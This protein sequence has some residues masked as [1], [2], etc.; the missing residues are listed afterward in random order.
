MG[1][2]SILN[3]KVNKQYVGS[4]VYINKRWG[5]HLSDLRRGAHPNKHLQRSWNL[6]GE[7]N[8]IFSL[9]EPIQEINKIAE[10]EQFWMNALKPAYNLRPVAENNTGFR[11]SEES[12][13][14]MSEASRARGARPPS[15]AG[16]SPTQQSIE[17]Q[18]LKLVGKKRPPEVGAKISASKKGYKFTEEA[19]AKMSLAKLGNQN[20][21]KKDAKL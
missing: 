19:R 15:R 20:R 8:F 4:S 12:K 9:L 21:R 13:K 2:Y 10:R 3:T 11:H 1:I 16:I 5:S 7:E 6:H 18:R 17:K 14:K